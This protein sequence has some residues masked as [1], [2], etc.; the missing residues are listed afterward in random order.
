MT[1]AF[2]SIIIPTFN[3]QETIVSCLQSV[4]TQS[5]SDVE[6]LVID[7][8]S[9]DATLARI[10]A[11]SDDRIIVFSE[12]DRGVYDAMNK[13]IK[14][15]T[16]TWLYFLGSDD[17]L[18]DHD[19]LLHVSSELKKSDCDLL[20]GNVCL[21]GDVEWAGGNTL[22]DGEF[23]TAKLF[24]RNVC[25]QAIFYRKDVFNKLGLFNIHY[26]ISA[27][28]DFNHRCF[29]S[30]RVRFYSLI[31]A[32]FSVAGV[33]GNTANYDRFITHDFV[34]VVKRYYQISYFNP[35][36]APSWRVFLNNARE[37]LA[38]GSFIKSLYFLFFALLHSSERSVVLKTYI[39]G[40]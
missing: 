5:F 9:S 13:G 19:V 14:Q 33:S 39:R 28:W 25:H 40:V 31:I 20:Y 32:D 37:L 12:A 34:R 16:G 29:A 22:Y 18:H 38:Q 26:K 36:F 6:V 2:F 23:S 8:K 4:L 35:L 11:F 3:S 27:D 17:Y 21:M 10:A 7:G 30:A 1:A 24:Q 15:A